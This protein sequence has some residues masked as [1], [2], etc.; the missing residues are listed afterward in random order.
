MV[1]RNRSS[2]DLGGVRPGSSEER[3]QLGTQD[4]LR[5]QFAEFRRDHRPRTRIPA[6]LRAAALAAIRQGLGR[7]EVRR[8]CGVSSEQ[9]DAWQRRQSSDLLDA[10][11]PVERDDARVFSV[12]TDTAT[13]VERNDEQPLEFRV[14]G[15]SITLRRVVGRM[16]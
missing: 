16:E 9:L 3:G 8:A 1:R 5:E 4:A 6:N 7:T 11:A 13:P 2:S 10:N 14:N 12:L 15:W